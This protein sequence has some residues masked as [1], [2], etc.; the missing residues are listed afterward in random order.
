MPSGSAALPGIVGLNAAGEAEFAAMVGPL[1][2]N[3]PRFLARLAAARPF[4]GPDAMF[5]RAREIALAMPGAEQRELID[6]HPR[7]GAGPGTVSA[8]SFREQGYAADS[9]GSN[10]G[11]DDRLDV[12]ARLDRLNA[13]YERRFGFRFVVFV[14]GRPR[15]EIIPEL[16]RR[17]RGS[18]GG[19]LSTALS[20]VVAIA[21]DRWR[22]LRGGEPEAT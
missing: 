15:S 12:Q 13:A 10:A 14:A 21:E 2:E 6:A 11:G 16:E 22:V 5:S 18:P 1:F 17:L 7:I 9:A 3:A 19:E 4:A 8:L 20:E